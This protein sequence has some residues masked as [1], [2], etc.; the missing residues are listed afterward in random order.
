MIT[1]AHFQAL[2]D[3]PEGARIAEVLSKCGLVERAGQGFDLIYRTCIRQSKSLPDFSR[4][5]EN[6]VWVTLHGEIQDPDFLRFLE[7]I[8]QERLASFSTEDFLFIDMVHR[9]LPLPDYL[10]HRAKHLLELGVIERI[11]RGRGTR[12]ILSRRFY[13]FLGKR[14]VYTRQKGLD[15]ETN[16]SLLL[17]HIRAVSATGA[18]LPELQQVLPSLSR[19]QVQNLMRDLKSEGL[20]RVCGKTKAAR[21]FPSGK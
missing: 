9:E 17:R 11:G 20:V 16:K 18:R 5:G 21:W 6:S 12:Y 13:T 19:H 2:I 15:R 8:G 3:A 10:L 14:G 7:Q 4:T 1:P